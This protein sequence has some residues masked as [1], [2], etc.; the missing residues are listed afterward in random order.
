MADF[1]SAINGNNL[2]VLSYSPERSGWSMSMSVLLPGG[3]GYRTEN[4]DRA[5][6]ERVRRL[7]AAN[8]RFKGI[9]LVEN[10]ACKSRKSGEPSARRFYIRYEPVNPAGLDRRLSAEQDKQL[11]RAAAQYAEYAVLLDR[12]L[13]DTA[14]VVKIETGEAYTVTPAECDCP[15]FTERLKPAGIPE[16]KH[17]VIVRIAMARGEVGCCGG[18]L[19]AAT[20]VPPFD[21]FSPDGSPLPDPDPDMLAAAAEEQ[22]RR[23]WEEDGIPQAVRDRELLWG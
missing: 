18:D 20:E 22:D 12:D 9:E 10:P 23:Q 8:P 13:S 15:H 7:F 14:R 6:A 11:E 19:R 16:C 5:T 21:P 3:A 2:H 17:M 1:F 4:M